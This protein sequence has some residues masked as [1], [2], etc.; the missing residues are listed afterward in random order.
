MALAAFSAESFA[1]LTA[2]QADEF[3]RSQ[4]L[5]WD[6]SFVA[7]NS[8]R[9]TD[10]GVRAAHCPV[11]TE[12]FHSCCAWREDAVSPI[13]GQEV[14][15]CPFAHY[16]RAVMAFKNIDCSLVHCTALVYSVVPY[17]ALW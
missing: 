6:L 3:C 17:D 10:A 9:I 1:D 2:P 7:W 16:V 8:S 11:R 15:D 4:D 13:A 5:D 14:G 12:T